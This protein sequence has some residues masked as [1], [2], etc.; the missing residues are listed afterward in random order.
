VVVYCTIIVY[1]SAHNEK[2]QRK[3]ALIIME[4][5]F[6]YKEYDFEPLGLPEQDGLWQV[7]GDK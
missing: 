4:R 1:I 3:Y 7:W 6:V 2:E 5:K